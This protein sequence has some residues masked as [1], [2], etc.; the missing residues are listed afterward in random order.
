M[1]GALGGPGQTA[2]APSRVG[3]LGDKAGLAGRGQM[4]VES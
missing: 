1:L 3:G 4:V 2:M